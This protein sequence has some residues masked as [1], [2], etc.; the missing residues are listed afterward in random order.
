MLLS[1]AAHE[2]LL[3]DWPVP[4]ETRIN[5]HLSSVFLAGAFAL[6]IYKHQNNIIGDMTDPAFRRAFIYEDF[7]WNQSM[8]P[9]LYIHVQPYRETADGWVPCEDS[10][11]QDW[12]IRMHRTDTS[13]DLENTIKQGRA[14]PEQLQRAMTVMLARLSELTERVRVSTQSFTLPWH[15]I[16]RLRTDDLRSWCQMLTHVIP[17]ETGNAWSDTLAALVDDA[18]MRAVPRESYLV[19]IDNHAG[20]LILINDGVQFIDIY[21]FKEHWKPADPYF[22]AARL[23]G[24]AYILGGE[25]AAQPM[26]KA[27]LERFS[28]PPRHI[29]L[30]YE[31]YGSII[32]AGLLIVTGRAA[33]APPFI[34]CI[35]QHIDE[36]KRTL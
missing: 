28:L 13:R 34:R 16:W 27:Y 23:V 32:K 15:E 1:E 24:E 12:A 33:E 9:E 17:P 7:V 30:A 26:M 14:T 25:Q 31:S 29:C 10:I 35:E 11:A 19:A 8:S 6:K 22:V 36:I 2:G 18:Y 4:N 3:P 21:P 5:T 20:N